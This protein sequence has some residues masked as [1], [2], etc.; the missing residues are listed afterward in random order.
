MST[1]LALVELGERQI[2]GV[3]GLVHAGASAHPDFRRE[4]QFLN[5]VRA[6][7]KSAAFGPA[8]EVLKISRGCGQ[9]QTRL[10]FLASMQTSLKK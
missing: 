8:S 10:F 5:L 3:W 6:K 7:C 4:K 2:R 9:E 1:R